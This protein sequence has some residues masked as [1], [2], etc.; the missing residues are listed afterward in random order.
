M[1]AFSTLI[2]ADEEVLRGN[3]QPMRRPSEDFLSDR[4]MATHAALSLVAE[5]HHPSVWD[6]SHRR[7]KSL[8]QD[9]AQHW[10]E[11]AKSD[12]FRA[13]SMRDKHV[14]RYLVKTDVHHRWS[15]ACCQHLAAQFTAWDVTRVV[16]VEHALPELWTSKGEVFNAGDIDLLLESRVAGGLVAME[17]KTRFNPRRVHV[18]WGQAYSC[19]MGIENLLERRQ[20]GELKEMVWVFFTPHPKHLQVPMVQ[21]VPL[22][23][24]RQRFQQAFESIYGSVV[25][26]RR[27]NHRKGR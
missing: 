9:K 23:Y 11:R 20:W 17:I 10:V 16:A 18:G 1:D 5:D 22:N 14:A 3:C 12:P 15:A 13:M 24:D 8:L 7:V 19:S 4:G 6:V 25:Q 26:Y 21:T 2:R 27:A